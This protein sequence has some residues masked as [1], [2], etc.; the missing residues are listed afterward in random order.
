MHKNCVIFVVFES[1]SN[2]NKTLAF[3]YFRFSARLLFE[4]SRYSISLRRPGS[5]NDETW[6]RFLKEPWRTSANAITTVTTYIGVE[7]HVLRERA[8]TNEKATKVA[9]RAKAFIFGHWSLLFTNEFGT[10]IQ[11]SGLFPQT[12]LNVCFCSELFTA[13]RMILLDRK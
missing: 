13:L 5:E 8:A 7:L 1:I 12:T 9:S 6:T 2:V 3:L 4:T 11:S 10:R